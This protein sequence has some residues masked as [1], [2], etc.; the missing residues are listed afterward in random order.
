MAIYRH[1]RIFTSAKDVIFPRFVFVWFVFVC[2][3]VKP[4]VTELLQ[5]GLCRVHGFAPFVYFVVLTLY[6]ATVLSCRMRSSTLSCRFIYLFI[7]VY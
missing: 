1:N 7:F 5:A 2:F 3:K 6:L 4:V